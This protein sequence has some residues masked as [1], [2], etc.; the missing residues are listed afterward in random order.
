MLKVAFLGDRTSL[1]P[2]QALGMECYFAKDEGKIR[3]ILEGLKLDEY[4]LLVFTEEAREVVTLFF[5]ERERSFPLL[6]PLPS[7]KERESKQK[8]IISAAIRRATGR[9]E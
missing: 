8:K 1:L 4:G 7:L 2:F 5:R 6:L 9:I 3:E